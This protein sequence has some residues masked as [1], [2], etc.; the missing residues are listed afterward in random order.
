[1]KFFQTSL[2]SYINQ[3]GLSNHIDLSS[4][5]GTEIVASFSKY[6]PLIRLGINVCSFTNFLLTSRYLRI[7]FVRMPVVKNFNLIVLFAVRMK[8]C[9]RAE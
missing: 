8:E 1:M 9:E 3:V 2:Q 5:E 4:E 6:P 7:Q